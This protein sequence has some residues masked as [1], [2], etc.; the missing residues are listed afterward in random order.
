MLYVV[1]GG[2]CSGKSE[3]AEKLAISKKTELG[4]KLYYIATM[5]AE[6][7]E[8]LERIAVH[9]Q[10]RMGKGFETIECPYNISSVRPEKN[11]CQIFL[12]MKCSL[13]KIKFRAK[14]K[15]WNTLPCLYSGFHS[16][17]A[18]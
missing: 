7:G 18:S 13:Q 1:T 16:I 12:Q 5:C 9:R 15:L 6:D 14:K 4:G 17:T 2:A 11:V 10:R 3:Y 8:S